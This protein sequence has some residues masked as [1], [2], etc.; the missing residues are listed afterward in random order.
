MRS[1]S[2][3]LFRVIGAVWVI[4]GGLVSA[5]T[6]PL[7]LE[8]GSWAAAFCV[9]VAGVSQFALGTIQAA[10]ASKPPSAPI[11]ATELVA[12]NAGSALVILGTVATMPLIVDVGGLF[13]VVALAVLI[14]TVR[15]RAEPLWALWAYRVLLIVILASIPIGLVLAHLRAG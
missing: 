10:L 9:L 1:P 5:L 8:H 6:G 4:V 3:R 11:V 12:W 14:I 2:E 15:G 13:L 7:G